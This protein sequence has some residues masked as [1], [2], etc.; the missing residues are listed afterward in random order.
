MESGFTLGAH[1]G[2]VPDSPLLSSCLPRRLA[3][4]VAWPCTRRLVEGSLNEAQKCHSQPPS[5]GLS[6]RAVFEQGFAVVRE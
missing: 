1:M 4:G 2:S 6:K 3:V 5:Y